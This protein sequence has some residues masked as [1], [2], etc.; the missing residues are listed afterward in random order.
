MQLTNICRDVHADALLNR[1]YLPQS[2][3]GLTIAQLETVITSNNKPLFNADHREK[4]I[5]TITTLLKQANDY[6]A[7]AYAGL[8]YLPFR[9]R[10]S[11]LIAA[12]L[13][14]HIGVEIER[15][16][17]INMHKKVYVPMPTKLMLT[18]SACT[19]AIFD[20]QFWRYHT[21][22]NAKLH[23]LMTRLPFCHA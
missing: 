2:L 20:A 22:H 5:Q 17:F 19:K 3:L 4:V 14:Q 11:I 18:I 9:S 12:K 1:V 10:V 6:Y 23:R 13:Y 15:Q 7:S 16:Q 21:T 8:A